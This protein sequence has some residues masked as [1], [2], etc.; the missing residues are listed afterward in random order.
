MAQSLSA[1]VIVKIVAALSQSIG[2]ATPALAQINYPL[3]F[4][5]VDGGGAGKAHQMYSAAAE[6]I[7]ASGTKTYDLSGSLKDAFNNSIAFTKVKLI[8][9]KADPTNVNDVV[10][11]GAASNGFISLFGDPTDK[12]VVKPGGLALLVAPDANGYAAV[13]ATADQF[14]FAN[15]GSG[16]GVNYDLLMF[17]E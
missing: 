10:I 2:L 9:V 5:F 11:G 14:K 7:A 17:G 8:M 15:S 16:T 6:N 1:A 4:D 3:E 13:D 12:L